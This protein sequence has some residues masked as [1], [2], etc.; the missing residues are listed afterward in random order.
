LDKSEKSL[1][2][3]PFDGIATPKMKPTKI[4]TSPTETES[5]DYDDATEGLLD[6]HEKRVRWA[7]EAP[8]FSG[9]RA[10]AIHASVFVFYIIT[11]IGL[12]FTLSRA[13]AKSSKEYLRC[14]FPAPMKAN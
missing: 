4:T 8:W 12:V 9:K 1:L 10:I 11:T 3:T 14:E 7:D 6:S 2:Q 13:W 5:D